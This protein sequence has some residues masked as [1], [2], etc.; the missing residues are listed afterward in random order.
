VDYIIKVLSFT[1]SEWNLSCLLVVNT[2]VFQF[3]VFR[4]LLGLAYF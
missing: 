1:T 3:R 2:L 4:K